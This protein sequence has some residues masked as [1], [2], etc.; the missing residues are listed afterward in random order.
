MQLTK[1][2]EQFYQLRTCSQGLAYKS[3]IEVEKN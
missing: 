1:K 3:K 2:F